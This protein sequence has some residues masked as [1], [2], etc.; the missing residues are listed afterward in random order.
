MTKTNGKSE[1]PAERKMCSCGHTHARGVKCGA[2]VSG[3]PMINYCPCPGCTPD[4]EHFAPPAPA[5]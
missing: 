1:A 3:T 5:E 4:G 2:I